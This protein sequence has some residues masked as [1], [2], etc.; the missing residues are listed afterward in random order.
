MSYS[1]ETITL[2]IISSSL[3]PIQDCV[4][5]DFTQGCVSEKRVNPSSLV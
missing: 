1:M 3:A 4:L 2:V 5:I